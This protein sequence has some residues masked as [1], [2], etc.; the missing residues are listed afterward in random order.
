MI[1]CRILG[2]FCLCDR[3]RY[4][5]CWDTHES[6][7]I[8]FIDILYQCLAQPAQKVSK[9]HG[10]SECDPWCLAQ[11]DADSAVQGYIVKSK[12]IFKASHIARNDATNHRCLSRA[13]CARSW[14]YG[15]FP[16]SQHRRK[17][18]SQQISYDT[19]KVSSHDEADFTALHK[20]YIL[21]ALAN[22]VQYH[23]INGH[24]PWVHC[25]VDNAWD[26]KSGEIRYGCIIKETIVCSS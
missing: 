25:P 19:W 4:S 2:L 23:L 15:D 22:A 9:V 13:G 7:A 14:L 12:M 8:F 17:I 10:T 24:E 11:I 20:L 6:V 1:S 18:I 26:L 16:N 21:E 3:P 5:S